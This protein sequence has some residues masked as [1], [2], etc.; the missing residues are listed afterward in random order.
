[1]KNKAHIIFRLQTLTVT[2]PGSSITT[3]YVR[4]ASGNVMSV[5]TRGDNSQNAGAL[6]QSE[7]HL[8]ACPLWWGSNRIGLFKP[9][10]NVESPPIKS[11]ILLSGVGSAYFQSFERGRKIY[12]LS[13]HLGNVL[14]T[15]SDR[16]IAVDTNQNSYLDYYLADIRTTARFMTG[17]R[18][19]EKRK[20]GFS[21]RDE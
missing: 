10:N 17:C 20:T 16:R 1:M 13:N 3:W 6:T 15:V 19:M 11:Y 2:K 12:E 21:C 18:L 9:D 14:A 5:Y 4:D 7:T 8:Y